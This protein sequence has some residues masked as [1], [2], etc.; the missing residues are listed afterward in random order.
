MKFFTSIGF[1]VF[2]LSHAANANPT[3]LRGS[4]SEEDQ[5]GL[6]LRI[7]GGSL[8][9]Q[10]EF[11]SYAVPSGDEGQCGS[12][13]IWDDILLS[14]GHCRGAF[15]GQDMFIGGNLLSGGDAPETIRA[16][17]EL[18]HPRYN[19]FTVQNDIMLIKLAEPSSAPNAPWNT[20]SSEPQDGQAVTV[21]G[22]GATSEG[23]DVSDELLKVTVNIVD[24]DTCRQ[25]YGNE[26]FEDVMFCAYADNKDSCQGDR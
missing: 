4:L 22:F 15:Q 11:P 24:T 17:S 16:S 14:A 5:R 2:V 3:S 23:G 20:A 9:A 1:T 25:T 21:I 26:L 8:A 19:D 18:V 6:G 12:V 13:K 10:G 7:V